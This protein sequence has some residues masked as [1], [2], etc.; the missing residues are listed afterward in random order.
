[1]RL[2][3]RMST[4]TPFSK[5][6][7]SRLTRATLSTRLRAKTAARNA[8]SSN[9]GMPQRRKQDLIFNSSQPFSQNGGSR[10]LCRREPRS[11]GAGWGRSGGRSHAQSAIEGGGQ[12][13]APVGQNGGGGDA[14]AVHG[15]GEGHGAAA[16]RGAGGHGVGVG[17]AGGNRPAR[18]P[19]SR[20]NLVVPGRRP[21]RPRPAGGSRSRALSQGAAPSVFWMVKVSSIASP[22]L[23]Q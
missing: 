22:C 9:S 19:S 23:R 13:V 16:G 11:I 2:S 4:T 7:P 1:M 17:R 12:V 14:L 15:Q 6:C 8:A 10:Q 20:L 21:R 3:W 5:V 18:C